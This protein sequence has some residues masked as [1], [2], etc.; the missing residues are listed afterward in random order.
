MRNML[1]AAAVVVFVVSTG[2]LEMAKIH[3]R[4]IT[5]LPPA[6]G[7]FGQGQVDATVTGAVR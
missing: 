2:L 1:T 6:M 5:A 3:D 4:P 7:E